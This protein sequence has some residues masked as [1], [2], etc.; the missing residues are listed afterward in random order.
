MTIFLRM[1]Q[2]DQD[3]DENFSEGDDQDDDENSSGDD[4]ERDA[5]D[6]DDSDHI[7]LSQQGCLLKTAHRQTSPMLTKHFH[8]TILSPC[9]MK[10]LWGIFWP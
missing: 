7:V 2:D 6:N 5:D 8:S 3:D 1:I 10:Y 9:Y 4:K